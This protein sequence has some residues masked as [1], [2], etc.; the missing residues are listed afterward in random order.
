M[1]IRMK[2]E[3]LI[4]DVAKQEI[5]GIID[6]PKLTDQQVAQLMNLFKS[7]TLAILLQ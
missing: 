5:A 6:N 3:S 7:L 1:F 4:K 2:Q